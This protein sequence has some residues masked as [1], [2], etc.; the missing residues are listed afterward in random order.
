MNPTAEFTWALWIVLGGVVSLNG[1]IVWDWLRNRNGKRDFKNLGRAEDMPV[2]L[3]ELRAHCV[4]MR[5]A[6]HQSLK[7]QFELMTQE[8][9]AELG[10]YQATVDAALEAGDK[11]FREIDE[12]LN[13]LR[14][15]LNG[16]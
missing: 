12:K 8:V 11:H 10:K 5:E 7:P 15:E 1:K 13:G 6:C 9:A 16:G 4:T 2:T 14:R 3:G